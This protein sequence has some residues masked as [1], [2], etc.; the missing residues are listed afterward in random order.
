MLWEIEMTTYKHPKL[1]RVAKQVNLEE[2]SITFNDWFV[3]DYP[4]SLKKLLNLWFKKIKKKKKKTSK[5]TR[6][7]DL[8]DEVRYLL[9]RWRTTFDMFE[10]FKLLLQKHIPPQKKLTIQQLWDYLAGYG[11]TALSVLNAL[12]SFLRDHDLLEE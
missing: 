1:G 2:S 12:E 7:L 6:Q 5:N 8:Y 9:W 10:D 4:F 3:V 11:H